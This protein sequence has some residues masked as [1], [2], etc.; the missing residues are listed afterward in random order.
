MTDSKVKLSVHCGHW[1]HRS[2]PAWPENS[3]GRG[4]L[5]GSAFHLLSEAK[6][7]KMQLNAS[8]YLEANGFTGSIS[9]DAQALFSVAGPWIDRNVPSWA[10]VE[11]GMAFDPHTGESRE[12]PMKGPRD[13][14]AALPR[15]I[16]GTIDLFWVD[17]IDEDET[18]QLGDETYDLKAGQRV[19]FLF[20]W[21][22][23]RSYYKGEAHQCDQIQIGAIKVAGVYGCDVA[24]VGILHVS[25]D[26]GVEPRVHFMDELEMAA[27]KESFR[28]R[29][30][31]QS[32]P[33]PPKPGG[34]CI[35]MWCPVRSTCSASRRDAAEMSK[36]AD[37]EAGEES[38]MQLVQPTV[39]LEIHSEADWHKLHEARLRAQEFL[40]NVEKTEREWIQKNGH[41]TLSDGKVFGPRKMTSESLVATPAMRV[42]SEVLSEEELDLVAPRK[43][44]KSSLTKGLPA[45][46]R[47][48]VMEKLREG[49]ATKK[50]SSTR[51]EAK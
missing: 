18:F 30:R 8:E 20:D 14:T 49:G 17:N 39:S 33:S 24:I 45:E 9:R 22:T 36:M 29:G 4:A 19:V 37:A 5:V 34:W 46:R 35:G 42:L 38:A 43:V 40:N 23:G 28:E 41:V 6:V 21:E 10:R 26:K 3:V 47:R 16:P 15:E 51:W 48:E 7:K 13:Y 27:A 50:T 44:S 25:M 11:V 2:G 12:I 1:A 31:Y 32:E